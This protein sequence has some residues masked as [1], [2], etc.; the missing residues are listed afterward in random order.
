MSKTGKKKNFT[1]GELEALLAE[2][3]A[4]KNVLFGMLS[5]GISNKRKRSEWES[6]C[7]AVNA[8]GSEKRTQAEVKKKWSDIKVDIKR[9]MAAHRQSVAKTGGGTGEEGPAIVGETT[10][11]QK[12]L[13][14]LLNNHIDVILCCDRDSDP[15]CIVERQKNRRFSLEVT[16]HRR[17]K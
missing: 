8:V 17:S 2:V 3:E 7:E 14:K 16:S 9:R 11:S 15:P 13:H 4:P 5:S 6:V 10:E 12:C 1:E